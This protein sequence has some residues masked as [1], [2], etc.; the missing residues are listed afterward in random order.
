MAA[1]KRCERCGRGAVTTVIDLKE[2]APLVVEGKT[3]KT[4]AVHSTHQVCEAHRR[5]PRRYRTNG[6]F[7]EAPVVRPR[8]EPVV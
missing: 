2:E 5:G 7:S 8:P 3:Y 1:F 4:W 6:A